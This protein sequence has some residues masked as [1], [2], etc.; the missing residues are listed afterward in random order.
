M[1]ETIENDEVNY[2]GGDLDAISSMIAEVT[3]VIE[4]ARIA[5]EEKNFVESRSKLRRV[6]ELLET[7]RN[8]VRI[9]EEMK[10]EE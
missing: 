10:S 1:K 6:D 4:E 9:L 3:Q 2:T 8:R 7:S 5:V